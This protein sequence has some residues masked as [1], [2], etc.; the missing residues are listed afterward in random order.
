ML[1]KD[2]RIKAEKN[3]NILCYLFIPFVFKKLKRKKILHNK[4]CKRELGNF[5]IKIFIEKI[6]KLW[7]NY[8]L[9]NCIRLSICQQHHQL[10]L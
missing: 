7:I 3:E 10:C 9:L 1:E 8:L 4:F 5:L 6:K 2:D